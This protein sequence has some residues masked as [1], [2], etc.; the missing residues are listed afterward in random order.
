MSRKTLYFDGYT[1]YVTSAVTEN[2]KLIEFKFEKCDGGTVVGNVYKGRVESV[3]PGMRAAFIDCGLTRNCYLSDEDA[4]PESESYDADNRIIPPLPD[5]KEGDEIMV[6]VTKAPVGKKGA[7]VTAHPH[8]VGKSLIYMPDLPVVGVSRKITDK[9]LRNNLAYAAGKLK[10]RNEGLVIR[11]SAPYA[12]RNQVEVEY[13][14]LKNLY[15]EIKKKYRTAAVGELLYTD[16]ALPMRVLRDILSDDIE[17]IVVGNKAL[18]NVVS[19][20]VN[21]YPPHNRRPITLHDTGKDMLDELGISEQIFSILSPRAELENGAYLIIEK[22]EALT[23]I[24]VNTGKF[25]GNDDP[26][27]TVYYTN[28]LAAREIARQVRLRNIGGIVV[29]DFI[30]MHSESHRKAL[31]EELERA[32][33]NDRA[34]CT[35]SPMSRFGLVE[36]TRKRVGNDHFA[37]MSRPCRECA[38]TGAT[39]S[40][41]FVL[42]GIRAKL[43][44][45]F[46]EKA[47]SVRID[48]SDGVHERLTQW[49]EMLEDLK[50][51]GKGK[52]VYAVPHKSYRFEQYH[53]T[54]S[55]R[56]LPETATILCE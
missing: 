34:K 16:A 44:N 35:V 11:T 31:V 32:L 39:M 49:R 6:Q 28:I 15:T 45:L 36:F 43:L 25:T 22:T 13:A 2:G 51:L 37:L 9:E 7:R 3:L 20:I 42:F 40:A 33:K 41:E 38:G 17:Q 26:E 54:L 21:L 8:F 1:G 46:A 5:F 50:E 12:R 48:I 10:D 18:G 23:V 30:D 56:D 4:F 27:Q 24:D 47:E 52:L 19:D 55:P 14:Y 53:L 29:V